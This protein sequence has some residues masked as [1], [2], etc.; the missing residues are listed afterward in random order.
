MPH[1]GPYVTRFAPSPTGYL[2]LGHA[3]SALCAFDAARNHDGLCHLRI[4]D[5]DM[6]RC[7]PHFEAQI[8]EDLKA[9]DCHWPE[10]MIRQSERR[11][12]Y[13]T[14]LE[15]LKANGLVYPCYKT[16]KHQ[17]L[18]ALNAPQDGPPLSQSDHEPGL[19]P[20]FR[21]SLDAARQ[22]LGPLYDDLAFRDQSL[23]LIKARPEING[24]VVLGRRDTGI[25][26]HLCVVID[27]AAIGVSHI[28][29]GLDLVDATHTHVLLQALLGFQTPL[30]DHHRLILDE[31]GQRLAKRKGAMSLRDHFANG[32]TCTSLRQQFGLA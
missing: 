2:H 25:A 12:V 4:E 32:V 11:G 23:G 14:V 29:R 18:D 22:T 15:T 1:F 19:E 9:L 27:D 13:D 7:K 21:L 17:A 26:Y 30:Y 31:T 20:A 28:H 3:F 24:D 6:T 16:R 10:P 5:I 8:I